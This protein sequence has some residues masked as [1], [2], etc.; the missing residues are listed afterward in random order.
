MAW[1][2]RRWQLLLHM[3]RRVVGVLALVCSAFDN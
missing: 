3:Q 1:E 2:Q